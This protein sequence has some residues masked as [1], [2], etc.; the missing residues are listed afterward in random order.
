[1]LSSG[2]RATQSG[3]GGND[4]VP[5]VSAAARHLPHVTYGW[6]QVVVHPDH[7]RDE[8]DRIVHQVELDAGNPDLADTGARLL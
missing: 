4:L 3:R 7:H 6:V 5:V 1:M 2:P 8:D